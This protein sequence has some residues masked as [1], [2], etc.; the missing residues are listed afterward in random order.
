MPSVI[1]CALRVLCL[2]ACDDFWL[3]PCPREPSKRYFCWG[4]RPSTPQ[5]CSYSVVVYEYCSEQLAACC[6]VRG[7]LRTAL[8]LAYSA[9]QS[10]CA[11]ER[12]RNWGGSLAA[13][14][15]MPPLPAQADRK[16]KDSPVS[17][18]RRFAG[19]GR[20]RRWSGSWGQRQA[21]VRRL[22]SWCTFTTV[23]N[24]IMVRTRA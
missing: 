1:C 16:A 14:L 2:P 24:W 9:T 4:L 7:A 3:N 13:V 20:A 10:A 22:T 18:S 11:T 15:Q 6:M 19:E 23:E 21:P 12:S 5:Y 17:A 8:V